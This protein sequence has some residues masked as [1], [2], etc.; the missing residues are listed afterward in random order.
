[1]IGGQVMGMFGNLP[2][3]LP[4][5]KS[6]KTRALAVS[7]LNRSPQL[8]DVPT[9]AESGFPGFEV[10][11]WYGVCAQAAVPKPVLA[12]LGATLTKTLNV[13]EVRARLAENSIE[14]SPTTPEEFAAFIKAETERWA[15]VV[16]DAGIPKQ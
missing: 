1:V 14:V 4:A 8:P 2:E 9:V 16:K 13:P 6:G 3:Q 15:N 7:T 10:T 5:I 11:V 12:K